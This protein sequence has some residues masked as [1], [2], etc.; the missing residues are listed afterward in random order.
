MIIRG[1]FQPWQFC[2]SVKTGDIFEFKPDILDGWAFSYLSTMKVDRDHRSHKNRENRLQEHVWRI[3]LAEDAYGFC[4]RWGIELIWT[5]MSKQFPLE[6]KWPE[7]LF[8]MQLPLWTIQSLSILR[9]FS[10]LTLSSFLGRMCM[11]L[12]LSVFFFPFKEA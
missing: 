1:P 4:H 11:K 5:T 3:G 7:S 9:E 10:G 12:Q 2:D 8:L 6:Q